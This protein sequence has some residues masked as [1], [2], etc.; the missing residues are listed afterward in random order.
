MVNEGGEEREKD[1]SGEEPLS[2]FDE[3]LYSLGEALR[4]KATKDSIALLI[5][6]YADQ[7]PEHPKI[8]RHAIL[9]GHSITV[10]IL[11]AIGVMGYFKIISTETAGALLGAVVGGLYYSNRR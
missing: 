1:N 4:H 6:R 10:A 5:Q 9:W 8:Q 7:I 2:G 3:L 11:I